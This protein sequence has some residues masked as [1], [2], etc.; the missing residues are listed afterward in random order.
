LKTVRTFAVRAF[1]DSHLLPD[2][3]AEQS[4]AAVRA[5]QF[6]FSL[7]PEPV[8]DL[9]EMAADLAFDL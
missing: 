6:G 5:E 7:A 8:V 4:Q 2:F 3:P 9:K 1:V